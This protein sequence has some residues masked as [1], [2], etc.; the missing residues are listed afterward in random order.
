MRKYQQDGTIQ[1]SIEERLPEISELREKLNQL[2]EQEREKLVWATT[3]RKAEMARLET[4]NI[5]NKIRREQAVPIIE[6]YQWIAA[7]T[8]F[9]N[10]VPALDLLA[11]AAI[12]G[13]LIVDLSAIYEQKF[14]LEKGRKISVN[15]VS[16]FF[17]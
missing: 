15:L 11:T 10:P 12:N 5:L 6:Q 4:K 9:A 13:Q 16:S 1:E 7:A 14:S 2:L 8:A 3:I 17:N